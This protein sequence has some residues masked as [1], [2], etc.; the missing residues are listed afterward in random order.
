MG[1]SLSRSLLVSICVAGI[2]PAAFAVLDVTSHPSQGEAGKGPTVSDQDKPAPVTSRNLDSPLSSPPFPGSD[3]LGFP[4]VGSPYSAAPSYP[5]EKGLF[6]DRL[7]KK[8]VLVYGWVAPSF[9][10]STSHHSNAPLA[11]GFVP[12]RIELSQAALVIEKQPDSVQTSHVDYG[13][14]VA[15]IYGTDYRYTTMK[16]V[17]SD[18][19]LKR[20]Q[21]YGFDPVEMYVSAYLP[22]VVEGT[23]VRVGRF[24]SAPDIEGA[25][26]PG[27][28]T[29]SHSLLI[30]VDPTTFFGVN[31]MT[32]VNKQWQI[33]A[34]VHAGND[35]A[36]WSNSA[37][38]NFGL[39][40]R[41][42]SL[43]GKDGFWGGIN[44]LGDGRVRN[45][46][47]NL[48]HLV[49]T[50]GHK[51]NE[52]LHMMTEAYYMWEY[53]AN[54]GG[55]VVDG[56]PLFGTGGGAGAFLP[57]KSDASGLV[58]YFQILTSPKDY[59]SIR[60]DYL[61]DPRG[62]R[63][64]YGTAY[65]SHTLSYTRF[66]TPLITFR[67]EIRYEHAYGATPYDGG[68]RNSQWSLAADLVVRF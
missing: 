52:K 68:R 58:N 27:N 36:P 19:L 30:S 54:K 33:M 23:V 44:S 16:G 35:M 46:H 13:F 8:N 50:W 9:N 49:A 24:S 20:N 10:L 12:N 62:F 51:F 5:L 67:P 4:L 22:K 11:Y 14:R 59:V 37:A 26:A 38:P 61:N 55:T 64:G 18:A 31:S 28:Y 48:Q 41:W 53:G 65:T 66:L 43:D 40:A 3:W 47:D 57:G 6:G 34:Q 17:G 56:P 45:G 21:L 42:V 60:N 7:N 32:R 39:L 25:F 15:G 29:F 63:T 2:A 1:T